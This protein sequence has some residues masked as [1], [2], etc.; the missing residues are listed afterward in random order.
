MCINRN[1]KSCNIVKNLQTGWEDL[2]IQT[3]EEK[4]IYLTDYK[5]QYKLYKTPKTNSESV[6]S[7]I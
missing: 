4:L 1:M 3:K 5:E 2:V 6:I 7:T